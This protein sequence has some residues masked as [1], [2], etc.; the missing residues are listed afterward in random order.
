MA[1]NFMNKLKE[2]HWIIDKN[3]MDERKCFENKTK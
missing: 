1:L 2:Q 3:E